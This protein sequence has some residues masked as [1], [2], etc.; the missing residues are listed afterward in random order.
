MRS[1]LKKV[2]GVIEADVALPDK[3]VVKLD[4]KKISAKQPIAKQLIAAVEK[5][6]YKAQERE[7]KKEK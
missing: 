6:G 3:A 5:A 2:P 4:K 1:A 7:E